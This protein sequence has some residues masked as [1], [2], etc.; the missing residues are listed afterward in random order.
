M[1]NRDESG[2]QGIMLIDFLLMLLTIISIKM[3]RNVAVKNSLTLNF[4]KNKFILQI[5][6]SKIKHNNTKK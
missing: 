4:R 6:Y 1:K 2:N 3:K 5:K